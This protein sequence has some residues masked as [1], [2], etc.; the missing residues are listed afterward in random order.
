MTRRYTVHW[1]IMAEPVFLNTEVAMDINALSCHAR[2]VGNHVT[3]EA[4]RRMR[5][6]GSNSLHSWTQK[7]EDAR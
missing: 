5:P 6:F 4:G 2:G 7:D 1:F 3:E